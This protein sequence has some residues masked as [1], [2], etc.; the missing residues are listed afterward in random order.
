MTITVDLPPDVAARLSQ[1][2]KAAQGGQD[3]GG[4]VQQLAVRD[5]GLWD[6]ASLTA[7]DDLIDSFDAGDHE[8]HRDTIAAL[9][10]GL[11]EDRP[12]QRR[13]FGPGHNTAL[14]NPE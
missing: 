5:A 14:D 7:W 9:A 12:R 1:K 8:D 4:Y 11:N 3:V 13:V 10:R 6:A 2:Q